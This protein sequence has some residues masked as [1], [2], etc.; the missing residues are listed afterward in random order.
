MLCHRST[1][2]SLVLTLGVVITMVPANAQQ[3]EHPWPALKNSE[4]RTPLP[5][6]TLLEEQGD[7]SRLLVEAN[8]RFLDKEI[9]RTAAERPSHWQRDSSSPQAYEKSVLPHRERLAKILGIDREVRLDSSTGGSLIK[10]KA[11][12][13]SNK[14]FTTYHTQWRAFAGVHGDGE[15]LLPE[16]A[17]SA[18]VILIPDA[19]SEQLVPPAAARLAESGCRVLVVHLILRRENEIHLSDREWVQRP[20]FILGRTLPGYEVIKIQSAIDRLVADHGDKDRP[21]YIAGYGEGG[22]IALFTAALDSRIQSTLI[23][24]S[25]GPR[26]GLWREPA[27]HNAFG[28]LTEFGD[29]ELASLITPRKL[30][31]EYG[32][33]PHYAYRAEKDLELTFD[34]RSKDPGKPALLPIPSDTEVKTEL[35]RLRSFSPLASA[36]AVKS[37][38]PFSTAALSSLLTD[39][40]IILAEEKAAEK[41]QKSPGEVADDAIRS[42]A[43]TQ[44]LVMHN[45]LA[46]V[47][48][49]GDRKKYF[50]ELNTKSLSSFQETI[51]PY[52]DKF[53]SEVIGDFGLPLLPPQVKSRPYQEGEKTRSYEIVMDVMES[54]GEKVFTY[55]ILTLPKDLDLQSNEKRPVVVCQHGLEGT[56]QDLI[57]ELKYSA[58]SAFATRLAEDGFITF[59][60]Q[61]GYKY[62]DLF[63]LQQFKAQSI[64]KTL[65]SLIIPQHEQITQWLASQ[66]WVA[67]DQIAFYGLSYGGKSAMRIPA[68]VDRYCLSIC[69]GDFDDWVWKNAA[70]DSES[71]RY[72]YANKGEYE[73]FEWNLGGSFNYAEMA[74]LICPRPFMV[75]RGHFDGVAPDQQV[76]SEFAK[77]RNLYAARLGI[78]DKCEIEWF[79]GPHKINGV[80]TFAFLKRHLNWPRK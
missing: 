27:D 42:Q 41:T 54:G 56:P 26:E 37:D 64:G 74:A 55:G 25:F 4:D 63:R 28:L 3:K 8:D 57:G 44:E 5:G 48:S 52:R 59:A 35:N 71:L 76:G 6:T 39:S 34:E 80:G 30:V 43:R 24:G 22:R 2:L 73:I 51:A 18:D 70:T 12:T 17:I 47:D 69:S 13:Q 61:N 23:S 16:G 72:S 50:S 1:I 9:I 7:L 46:L 19:D 67:A 77:V 15:L 65:F 20:S 60:P 14:S 38:Q 32:S 40:K 45:R 33:Y 62:F 53:R 10:W 21:L 31:V 78:G 11:T 79:P 49:P 36:D 29:A 68:L 58:Y 75:E 66:P